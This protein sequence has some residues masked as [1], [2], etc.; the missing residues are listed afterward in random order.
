MQRLVILDRDG[1]INHDSPEFVKTADEWRPIEG[2]IAAIARLSKAGFTVAVASNQSG[3][4]R[5]LLDEADLE[6]MHDKLRSLV[7]D[8][9]GELGHIV[10]CPHLPDAGCLCRK[11]LPGLYQQLGELYEVS[12]D[13][14]PVV[15]DKAR[16][17]DAARAVNAR[18]ILVLTGGGV[19][20]A[21]EIDRRGETVET[22][23]DLAAVAAQLLAESGEAAS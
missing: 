15:G 2:S 8:S 23:A 14:V 1:V 19:A 3:I 18:P 21:A 17:L 20:T 5:E 13:G 7:R 6:S 11:P 9:G 12:L 4:G 10:Y 16:D 22:F